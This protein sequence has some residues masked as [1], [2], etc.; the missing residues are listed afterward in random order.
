MSV[1]FWGAA[2]RVRA[3]SS[4]RWI[5]ELRR[6]GLEVPA[7]E[8]DLAAELRGTP[9]TLLAADALRTVGALG[10]DRPATNGV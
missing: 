3:C 9:Q 8:H 1:P 10:T 2:A 7:L 6:R 4:L 5:D